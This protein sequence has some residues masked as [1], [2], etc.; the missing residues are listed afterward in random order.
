VH[1]QVDYRKYK[2]NVLV[3]K[4]GVRISNEP[5]NYGLK[6]VNMALEDEKIEVEFEKKQKSTK[7]NW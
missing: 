5:N 4:K 2:D 7:V 6:L 3:L 1:H